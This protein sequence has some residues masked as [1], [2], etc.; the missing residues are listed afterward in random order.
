VKRD[1]S[2]KKNER[3]SRV[4]YLLVLCHWLIEV[5]MHQHTLQSFKNTFL[6]RNLG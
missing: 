1:H 4:S 6:S 5:S 3:I 2:D